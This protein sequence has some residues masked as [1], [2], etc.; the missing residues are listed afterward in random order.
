VLN[1]VW[2]IASPP[3][4]KTEG[5]TIKL[6]PHHLE[7]RKH[8]RSQT[9][10]SSI[11]SFINPK[12]RG[13]KDLNSEPKQPQ[14]CKSQCRN[15][16]QKTRALTESQLH[17]RQ[18]EIIHCIISDQNWIRLDLNIKRNHIKYSNTWRLKNILLSIWQVS[19]EIKEEFKKFIESNKN[20]NN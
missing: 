7:T 17:H 11:K 18:I 15:I 16:K 20:T 3:K 14:I 6:L 1:K 2:N 5:N 12:C 13:T 9:L 19:E 4:K 8:I 10:C